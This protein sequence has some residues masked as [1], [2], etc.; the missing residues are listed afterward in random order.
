MAKRSKREAAAIK[1]D[2]SA[3]TCPGCGKTSP[4]NGTQIPMG[5]PM[6]IASKCKAKGCGA[7]LKITVRWDYGRE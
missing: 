1:M 7:E 5:L 3:E 2:V 4:T 6:T